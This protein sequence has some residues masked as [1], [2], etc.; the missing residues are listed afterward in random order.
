MEEARALPANVYKLGD[1]Q[2]IPVLN[3]DLIRGSTTAC[4]RWMLALAYLS[5][6]PWTLV[7]PVLGQQQGQPTASELINAV[8]SLRLSHGLPALQIHP[9]LMQTAQSQA[10]ALLASA[11]AVGHNRPGG[12]TFTEQLIQLGYPLAG[13]LSLG[14]YRS[15]NFVFGANL[16]IEAA[17]QLWLGDGSHTGT[18]LSPNYLDIGAGVAVGS[19]DAVYY[20]IDCAR[21][22]SSG[23]PQSGAA[24]LAGTEDGQSQLPNQYIV[25]VSRS[26]ARPDGVVLHEVRYGQSLWSIAIAYG[27]TIRNLRAL[28]DLSDTTIYEGQTLVVQRGATQ[29]VAPSPA[30]AKG[31]T[32]TPIAASRAGGLLPTQTPVQRAMP[33]ATAAASKAGDLRSSL[34]LLIGAVIAGAFLAMVLIERRR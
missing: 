29:P 22:T 28:N 19:D 18:M 23:Q 26:T 20:V 32:Q 3:S 12:M 33:I 6:V 11:G 17:I 21:P 16:T 10:N 8:N 9:I 7:R 30:A 1:M 27:T 24:T 15:E 2:A 5:S 25:P 13:D 14:G 4:F 34:G 31:A